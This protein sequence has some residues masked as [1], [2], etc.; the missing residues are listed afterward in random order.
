MTARN[1]SHIAEQTSTASV[2]RRALG[3]A[4]INALPFLAVLPLIIYALISHRVVVGKFGEQEAAERRRD[5]MTCAALIDDRCKWLQTLLTDYSMWDETY[6]V[7][8]KPDAF[9]IEQNITC[10]IPKHYGVDAILLTNARLQAVCSAGLNPPIRAALFEGPQLRAALEGK[11][12]RGLVRAG[13]DIFLVATAPVLPSAAPKK[14]T[15]TLTFAIR[16]DTPL[17]AK[18]AKM[19]NLGIGEY[20]DGKLMVVGGNRSARKFPAR[21]ERLYTEAAGTRRVVVRIGPDQNI[22][23]AWYHLH[24]WN[25]RGAGVLAT[26]TDRNTVLANQAAVSFKSL[27][28]VA[29]CL[30]A[31]VLVSL[32]MRA[33]MLARHALTD[34]LT[35]LY[36]HRYLYERLAQEI[37][38]SQRYY[39]PLSVAMLDIDHFKHVNDEYGHPVGDRALHELAQ[40]LRQ[41]MRDTDVVTRYGG[42][43]FLVIMPETRLG[44]AMAAAERVR[45]KVEETVFEFRLSGTPS[46][47]ACRVSVRFTVSIG[48]AAYP[49]HTKQGDELILASDLA[50]YAAKH[51]S[52]NAVR[53]YDAISSDQQGKPLDPMTIHLA[54]REGSLSAVRALAAAIDARDQRMRGHSEKVAVC[55]LAIGEVLRL[56]EEEM[57]TLRAAALLHDVGCIAIPDA[58]L[59]KPGHLTDEERAVVMTHSA[60]GADILAKAPQLAQVAK[61]VRHHHECYDG[62]GYPDG[63]VGEAIPLLSRIIAAADAFDAITSDRPH[64]AASAALDAVKRMQQSAGSQFDP[65]V[66]DALAE[67]LVSGRLSEAF[68]SLRKELDLAA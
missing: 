59:Q 4:S 3:F 7:A 37:A 23:Y 54:M 29:T 45:R 16:L 24:D 52:R 6:N 41:T 68:K 65:T 36:N 50:L 22:A 28:I 39:R 15:G 51:A 66:V 21:A 35:G 1:D 46:L 63:L 31:A 56:S 40:L 57:N 60:K 25:G 5:I 58:I 17:L 42:E 47:R 13:D 10:W 11:Y 55:A 12:S 8:V 38:R 18:F 19:T 67:L 33:S 64:R 20:V 48:V 14:P 32:Y 44:A 62:L 53:S 27:L 26:S 49:D 9:W 34:E 61:I 43:E 2:R 30:L